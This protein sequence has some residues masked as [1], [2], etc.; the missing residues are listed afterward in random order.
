MEKEAFFSF[1]L[2]SLNGT[3]IIL[4]AFRILRPKSP[5]VLVSEKTKIEF[6]YSFIPYIRLSCIMLP[7]CQ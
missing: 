1:N 4:Y 2:R 7:S 6:P 5:G 3:H